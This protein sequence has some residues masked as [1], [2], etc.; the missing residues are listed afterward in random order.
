MD[1]NGKV[2]YAVLGLG[3]GFAHATAAYHNEKANL[4]AVCDLREDRLERARNEFPGVQTYTDFD[5]MLARPDIDVI[6]VAVP[7]GLHAEFAC[8]VMEAGKD[9]LVEKPVDITPEAAQKIIDCRN[10]TGRKC[11][12]IHQNRFNV[13]MAPIKEA[14]DSGRLGKLLLGTFEVKWYRDQNY[15]NNDGGW[16]GTWAMDGGGSLMNQAV[17]TVDLMQWLMGKP[18]EV[19]SKMGVYNHEIET[20]D[21]TVS[22]FTFENG[23]NATFVSSTDTFPGICTG[24]KVYGTRGSIEADGDVIKLWKMMDAPENEE[25]E[26]LHQYGRGNGAAVQKDPTRPFGHAYQVNDIIDAVRENRSPIITPDEAIKAVRIINA[27]YESARTGKK[28]LL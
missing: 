27:V 1:Q 2:G 9:C 7:S 6:S 12:V 17:H 19:Y 10:R 8:R 25:R 26:I 22:L 3:V 11:G 28:V 13:N 21:M 16:R 24:I 15:Y 14:I 20:E 18:V 23:A 4:I 5:E